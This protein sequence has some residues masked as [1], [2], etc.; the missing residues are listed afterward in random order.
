MSNSGW[1]TGLLASNWATM[2]SIKGVKPGMRHVNQNE[3]PRGSIPDQDCRLERVGAD[4]MARNTA[5]FDRMRRACA[6]RR[7]FACACLPVMRWRPEI[8]AAASE[9]V[10]VCE[11]ACLPEHSRVFFQGHR[12][13]HD[14]GRYLHPA[15]LILR[16]GPWPA[17]AARCTREPAKL[18]RTIAQ[19]RLRYMVVT[20]VDRDDL[21]DGGAGHFAECIDLFA[22]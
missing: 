19:M 17:H 15:L 11:E 2:T 16:R 22:S 10:T 1:L 6:S 5:Q 8:A 9:L 12:H 20:S 18:A 4:K 21:R 14:P 13:L 3:K 7:G